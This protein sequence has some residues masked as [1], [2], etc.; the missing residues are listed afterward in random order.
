MN[1]LR[2]CLGLSGA[3]WQFGRPRE[4]YRDCRDYVDLWG[5]SRANYWH[6]S[7]STWTKFWII[8]ETVQPARPG[9][10]FEAFSALNAYPRIDELDAEIEQANFDGVAVILSLYH[11]YPL[12]S[13]GYSTNDP[14][15][16]GHD[17]NQKMPLDLDADG[18]YGWFLS[19]LFARYRYGVPR[20]P[21]GPVQGNPMGNPRGAYIYGL[22]PVNEPN[23]NL[24]P[25]DVNTPCHTATMIKTAESLSY[26]WAQQSPIQAVPTY[27]LGPAT[28]DQDA[29]TAH[30][31]KYD[32][33]T[34]KVLDVLAGWVPRS[35]VG[36]AHHNYNDVEI[37]KP[38]GEKTR[39]ARVRDLLYNKN[40]KGGSQNKY[41]W[42]TE[43][44]C[45]LSKV[46]QNR[47]TQAARVKTAYNRMIGVADVYMFSQH[48]MDDDAVTNPN[49]KTPLRE[50]WNYTTNQPGPP[51]R[52]FWTW[53][54]KTDTPSSS[55][56]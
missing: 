36:W 11:A 8:W 41:I 25:Q 21:T 48:G 28:S 46:G 53:G 4:N 52:V 45:R 56:P 9:N 44:G 39:V 49:F 2:K 6:D 33:F 30:H 54:S 22:M 31:T 50:D 51:R 5:I 3:L 17:A 26:F 27:V 19:W 29:T 16:G 7:R 35:Y 40:W 13:N 14:N 47:D 55:V 32:D 20:N 38:T 10:I 15:P 18:P 12:W 43:G 42:L 23:F 1:P 37:P 24:W 34:G